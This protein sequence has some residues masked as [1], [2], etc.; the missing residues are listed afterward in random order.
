MCGCV[1]V[2]VGV[3]VAVGVGVFYQ[4]I[5][6]DFFFEILFLVIILFISFFFAK[7]SKSS[8]STVPKLL[9]GH[10]FFF[11]G[12]YFLQFLVKTQNSKKRWPARSLGNVLFDF[13]IFWKNSQF[14]GIKNKTKE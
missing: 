11:F 5:F 3:G 7:S 12:L 2:W 14:F 4:N 6:F 1:G 9:V 10:R 8:K 13:L